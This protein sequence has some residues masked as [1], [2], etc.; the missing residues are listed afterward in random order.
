MNQPTPSPPAPDAALNGKKAA[1]S[2][3]SAEAS[4][5]HYEVPKEPRVSAWI[6]LGI[7]AVLLVAAFSL[8]KLTHRYG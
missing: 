3:T 5:V 2:E 1:T 4:A 8:F 7:V 6:V